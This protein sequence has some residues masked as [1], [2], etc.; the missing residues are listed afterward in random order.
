MMLTLQF[1]FEFFLEIADAISDSSSDEVRFYD[2]TK[3]IE[4]NEHKIF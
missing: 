1:L 2:L 3:V 4:M